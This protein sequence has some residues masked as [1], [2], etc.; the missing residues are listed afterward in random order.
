[1]VW[2]RS[3]GHNGRHAVSPL[4]SHFL[5]LLLLINV[6]DGGGL[7]PAG[8]LAGKMDDGAS[9]GSRGDMRLAAP[10]GVRC[11]EIPNHPPLVCPP[12]STCCKRSVSPGGRG[13]KKSDRCREDKDCNVCAECCHASYANASDCAA[14]VT[15]SCDPAPHAAYGCS[16]N[17]SGCCAGGM[18]VSKTLPNCLLIGDSV[19]HGTFGEYPWN[20][21]GSVQDL[22]KDV[23]PV[24]NIEGLDSGGEQKCFWSQGTDAATG[25]LVPWKVIHFNEG[26]HSLWPRVNTSSELQQYAATLGHFTE[27]LKRTGA[28]L[29]YGTMTPFMPEKYEF[30]PKAQDDV[31]KK[32][33][34]AVKT[35]RAHGVTL[36]DDLYKAVTNVCGTVYKDCP[37]CDDESKFHPEGKCGAHY[38]PAGWRLLSNQTAAYILK[39]MEKW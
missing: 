27:S 9:M 26:L 10:V 4:V 16:T 22:L 39:A 35:V 23:C 14:C 11:P 18:H 13:P 33:A 25:L 6:M 32:N 7:V 24:S 30:P 5:L 31:E 36:V 15:K 2:P 29:V 19:A 37:L 20:F 28:A 21:T 1:M 8:L 17:S 34:V 3:G 12:G 38:S